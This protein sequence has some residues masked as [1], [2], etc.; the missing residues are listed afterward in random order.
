ML[1]LTRASKEMRLRD[2]DM[3]ARQYAQ[4]TNAAFQY[5][6]LK[7]S[8]DLMTFRNYVTGVTHKP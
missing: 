3:R 1:I 8:V 5:S 2:A 7:Y 6:A 4:A